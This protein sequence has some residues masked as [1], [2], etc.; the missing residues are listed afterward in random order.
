MRPNELTG[1]LL[2]RITNTMVIIKE[3]YATYENKVAAPAH[4]D[5]SRGYLEATTTKWRND[6]ISNMMQFFKMK[7]FWEALPGDLCKVVTQNDQNTMMV[8]LG[9]TLNKIFTES[10][11]SCCLML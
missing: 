8:A 10:F 5:T 2:A 1:E 11:I 4:H 9:M 7:L 6:S 3:S